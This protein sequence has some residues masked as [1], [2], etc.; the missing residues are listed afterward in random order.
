MLIA[1]CTSM[2]ALHHGEHIQLQASARNATCHMRDHEGDK[3]SVACLVSAA[4]EISRFTRTFM[5]SSCHF[6]HTSNN[7]NAAINHRM[8]T[9]RRA[10]PCHTMPWLMAE[11][12]GHE[13]VV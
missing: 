2:T 7:C 8:R 10:V 5:R 13:R 11:S 6:A 9:P 12:N 4:L 1:I 3:W